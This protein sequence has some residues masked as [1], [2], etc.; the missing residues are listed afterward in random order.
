MT[1]GA[2]D[3]EGEVVDLDFSNQGGGSVLLQKYH[4][5]RSSSLSSAAA[6]PE[7][8]VM[9]RVTTNVFEQTRSTQI[10]R[11][12]LYEASPSLSRPSGQPCC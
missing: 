8:A 3:N 11:F 5:S 10:V 7:H 4:R 12:I 1:R 6:L 2:D 9:P